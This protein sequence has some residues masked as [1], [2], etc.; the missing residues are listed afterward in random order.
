DEFDKVEAIEKRAADALAKATADQKEL[1]LRVRADDLKVVEDYLRALT[2][3]RS[4]RGQLIGLKDLRGMDLHALAALE[5][6][7]VARTDEVSAACVQ[8]FLQEDAFKPLVDRLDVAVGS[9]EATAKVT[10]LA[11]FG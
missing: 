7:L 8:F 2:T 10:E 1:L 4:Q 9:I 11:P 3:L 6:E 5:N